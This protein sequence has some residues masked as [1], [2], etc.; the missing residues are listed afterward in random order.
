MSTMSTNFTNPIWVFSARTAD[1]VGLLDKFPELSEVFE[2]YFRNSVDGK[3]NGR[4]WVCETR[5]L[6]L[7]ED[8]FEAY[9]VISDSI[10]AV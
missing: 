2:E 6:N 5:D 4:S 3:N 10:R 8:D 9:T 1:T 7:T